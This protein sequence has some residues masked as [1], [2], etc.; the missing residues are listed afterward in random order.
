M[1]T[2]RVHSLPSPSLVGVFST[3]VT[4]RMMPSVYLVTALEDSTNFVKVVDLLW[5]T[6]PCTPPPYQ[7]YFI[8]AGNMTSPSTPVSLSWPLLQCPLWLLMVLQLTQRKWELRLCHTCQPQG[9]QV[10]H[11]FGWPADRLLSWHDQC[12][13]TSPSPDEGR[14][15]LV[16]QMIYACTWTV[17]SICHGGLKTD[18]KGSVVVSHSPRTPYMFCQGHF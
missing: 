2:G 16:W 7:R 3:A 9:F 11:K 1:A 6:W 4:P 17:H 13:S 12:H 10:L 8:D 18:E 14:S 5:Q 15:P